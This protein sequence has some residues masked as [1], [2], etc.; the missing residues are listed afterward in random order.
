MMKTNPYVS[1]EFHT[2]DE[3]YDFYNNYACCVGFSVR[4]TSRVSSRQGV[5]S[6]RFTCQKEEFSNYQ[7]KR[8]MSIESFTNQRT[9]EKQM[10][11]NKVGI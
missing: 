6:I 5:S 2:S 11:D 10:G 8:V 9:L 1:L 3:T 7:K 4:K